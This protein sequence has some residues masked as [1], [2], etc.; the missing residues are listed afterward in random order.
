MRIERNA[1]ILRR[2]RDDELDRLVEITRGWPT[3]DG[4]HWGTRDRG[5][6]QHKIE[7]SG[8]WTD[9]SVLDMAIEVEGGLVGEIQARQPRHALP[10]GVFELGV[11]IY[12]AG[13]RGRGLGG[14]A[15]IA[16][17]AHLFDQE[18]AHRVQLSTDVENAAMRRCADRIGFGYEG[19][20]RGFMPTDDGPH[21][22]AMY[23]ITKHDYG[24]VKAR[25]I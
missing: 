3:G 24:E 20:N 15:I 7:A 2:F 13:D 10:P 14:A 5:E 25:W 11:E 9:V 1:V 6:L 8:R 19:I 23:G 22:Y 12:E 16:I 18:Q 17:T 4:I 21:D